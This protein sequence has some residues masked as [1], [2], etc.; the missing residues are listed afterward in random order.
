MLTQAQHAPP[1]PAPY[2]RVGTAT[3][4]VSRGAER[5]YLQGAYLARARFEP[6]ARIEAEFTPGR[7]RIRLVPE[8]PRAV[9]AK[10][11]AGATVPVI[12]LHTAQLRAAFG[13]AT[14]VRV[15]VTEGEIDISLERTARKRISRCR[16][17]AAGSLC[18]GAGLLDEAAGQAGFTPSWAVEVSD[19]YAALYEA[20]HR[21]ATM[22]NQSVS[23]VDMED[24]PP[25]ELLVSGLDCRPWSR[26]LMTLPGTGERRAP[27]TPREAHPSSDL[28]FWLLKAA[29]ALNPAYVLVEQV[30]LFLKSA[31]AYL[32]TGALTRMGYHV[33]SKVLSPADYGYLG[34]RPRAVVAAT[35]DPAPIRWPTASTERPRLADIMDAPAA[36][37]D[38][39]FSRDT[40]HWF[41]HHRDT[42]TARGNGF[43][44]RVLFP[45]TDRIPTLTRRYFAGQGDNFVI[46]DHARPGEYR[47]MTLGEARRLFAVP[48]HYDLGPSRVVAGE[49]L[50]QG[51]HV[52][53]FRRVIASVTGRSGTDSPEPGE[54]PFTDA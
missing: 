11:R 37:A 23:D 48:P 46:G 40:K 38:L 15:R 4:G 36:T 20:N 50:G 19:R 39:F 43:A 33:E 5:I 31:A 8:G 9:C 53:L 16:N 32:L 52:D 3:V 29:D 27:D 14:S 10:Q 42:Q 30:P 17:G 51:V 22:F 21:G 24:L 6:A 47:W 35:S 13:S 49:A 1:S 26:K 34:D 2:L 44:G 18:S 28:V 45:E 12:D 41:F 25:V 7:V 54:P